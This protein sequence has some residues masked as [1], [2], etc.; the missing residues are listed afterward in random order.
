MKV[1]E[2]QVIAEGNVRKSDSNRPKAYSPRVLVLRCDECSR[3][4]GQSGYIKVDRAA[5]SVVQT[6]DGWDVVDIDNGLVYWKILHE[7]CDTDQRK[8]DF[9]LPADR[10]A[11][12]GDLLE[13]TAWLLRNNPELMVGTNWHGL[14]RRVL[15]DTREFAEL[16]KATKNMDRNE[17]RR[18]RYAQ[19]REGA[20]VATAVLEA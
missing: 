18:L 6:A 11:T 2:L 20:T 14:I 5:V 7:E 4:V 15:W 17:R 3:R 8:T 19:E 12:T 16:L 9:R 13:A 10:F 1:E